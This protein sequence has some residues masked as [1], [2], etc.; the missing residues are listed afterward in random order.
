MN[1]LGLF[2]PCVLLKNLYLL[3]L[4][5]C[6]DKDA[7][8]EYNLMQGLKQCDAVMLLGARKLESEESLLRLFEQNILDRVLIEKI[9]IAYV[10]VPEQSSPSLLSLEALRDVEYSEQRRME[11]ENCVREIKQ[12]LKVQIQEMFRKKDAHSSEENTAQVYASVS[13]NV[14][15]VFP[16]LYV[17]LLKDKITWDEA[18]LHDVALQLSSGREL[19]QFLFQQ[20]RGEV[21]TV[22]PRLQ[23]SLQE[24]LVHVQD[25]RNQHKDLL[26]VAQ[27]RELLDGSSVNV[28]AEE[29]CRETATGLDRL[30]KKV[31]VDHDHRLL[32]D[33]RA[34]FCL[35]YCNYIRGQMREV[36]E[37]MLKCT[38][39]LEIQ[40]GFSEFSGMQGAKKQVGAQYAFFEFGKIM[41]MFDV[42][43]WFRLVLHK[44]FLACKASVLKTVKDAFRT[45]FGKYP[46]VVIADGLKFVEFTVEAEF[47]TFRLTK[48]SEAE[49]KQTIKA[50]LR[51][52]F[53]ESFDMTKIAKMLE[54]Q[55]FVDWFHTQATH[56]LDDQLPR[57]VQSIL[58]QTMTSEVE[59]AIDSCKGC[60]G[61]FKNFF[62]SLKSKSQREKISDCLK[63][64]IA[65]ANAQS[66]KLQA[67]VQAFADDAA[68][69]EQTFMLAPRAPHAS[70]QE[71]D[72]STAAVITNNKRQKRE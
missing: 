52:L 31:T 41:P 4:P 33:V 11:Q 37:N 47:K 17:S 26:A 34:I 24:F 38:S 49:L 51:R 10:M 42:D 55:H 28:S 1:S 58:M 39:V 35:Q 53:F 7:D 25:L 3:D 44:E 23:H 5:G 60:I 2:A 46:G 14:F 67:L 48:K 56:L 12:D 40:D 18:Q 61:K 9:P 71:D 45:V 15:C 70:I 30:A 65:V 63:D 16:R 8:K 62:K 69:I 32:E 59:R 13:S 50:E 54:K 43:G 66:V 22:L 27:N 36:T 68:T 57:T 21:E 20:S 72:S 6:G 64:T 19:M 29:F